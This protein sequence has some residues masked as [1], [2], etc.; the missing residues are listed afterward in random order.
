MTET[1]AQWLIAEYEVTASDYE[2]YA[3]DDSVEAELGPNGSIY[4]QPIFTLKTVTD[5]GHPMRVRPVDY[6]DRGRWWL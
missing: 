2:Y 3:R 4:V 5:S 6:F 1:P